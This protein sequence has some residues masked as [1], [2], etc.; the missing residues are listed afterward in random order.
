[1]PRGGLF[2][3]GAAFG[4]V[5]RKSAVLGGGTDAEGGAGES[6]RVTVTAADAGRLEYDA[7][8]TIPAN[9][10]ATASRAEFLRRFTAGCIVC[11]A[12]VGWFLPIV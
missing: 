12:F 11:V 10:T 1:M 4:T 3:T 9:K 8:Q 6:A 5:G 7:Q 2:G